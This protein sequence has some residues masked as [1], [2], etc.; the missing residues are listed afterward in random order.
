MFGEP[1]ASGSASHLDPESLEKEND[2]SIEHLSD[3]AALLK[4]MTTS[5][6]TEVDQHNKLLERMVRAPA[7]SRGASGG[8]LSRSVVLSPRSK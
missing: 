7:F 2:K 5:I 8:D 3:R 6:K 1:A 4:N